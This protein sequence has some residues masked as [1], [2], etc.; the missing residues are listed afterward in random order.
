MTAEDGCASLG[1]IS[2]SHVNF[3]N[4]PSSSHLQLTY[5]RQYGRDNFTPV[6]HQNNL[7]ATYNLS[8]RIELETNW[9]KANILVTPPPVLL[10]H[11]GSC[12]YSPFNQLTSRTGMHSR[13]QCR[14]HMF[15]NFVSAKNYSVQ[16]QNKNYPG[17]RTEINET[18]KHAQMKANALELPM[19]F[20]E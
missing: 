16:K 1:Y 11:C 13:R 12:H 10:N 18:S 3:I 15:V 9:L 19:L 17:N 2:L 4:H 7:Y 6:S 14:S 20:P 8:A 5:L